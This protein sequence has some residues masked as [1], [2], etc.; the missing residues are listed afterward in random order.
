MY[1]S[2]FD[3]SFE[4]AFEIYGELFAIANYPNEKVEFTGSTPR[5]TSRRPFASM[6]SRRFSG[7]TAGRARRS[8][9][10]GL[11]GRTLKFRAT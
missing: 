11:P 5:L 7:A 9:P 4:S 3:L 1:V 2:E 10:F 8:D 6:T